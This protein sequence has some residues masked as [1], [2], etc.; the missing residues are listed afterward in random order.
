VPLRKNAKIELLRRTALFSHCS[1]RELAEIAMIADEIDIPD[2][3]AFIREG[4]RGREFFAMIEG[5][6]DVR[7]KGRRVRIK[8]GNEFFGEIALVSEA[9]R[10][11]TV[12]ATSPVR[13]LV[14][15]DRAFDNLMRRS[16]QLQLKVLRSLAERVSSDEA[17]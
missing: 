2:G 6:V 14:I 8:G 10:N 16:P 1:K 5:S 15:T 3:K 17:V 13:A 9:P 4:V 11:A 12:T 7:K